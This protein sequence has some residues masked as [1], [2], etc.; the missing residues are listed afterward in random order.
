MKFQREIIIQVLTTVVLGI[1]VTIL[2]AKYNTDMNTVL[3]DDM[4]NEI[5]VMRERLLVLES[6]VLSKG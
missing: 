5:S 1:G 6:A 3:I 4:Q 2:T